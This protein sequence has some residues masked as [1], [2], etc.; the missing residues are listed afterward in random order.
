[1]SSEYDVVVVGGVAAGLTMSGIAASLGAKTV[2]IE[3][4]RLGGDCTW[5][6]CVPSK[7]LLK[8]AGIAQTVRTAGRYGI[9]CSAPA[10]DFD[11]IREQLRRL[12]QSIYDDADSPAR[13][14]ALGV[15]VLGAAAKFRDPRTI[16]AAGHGLVRGRIMV[17]ATGA[18]PALPSI[19]GLDTADYLTSES[20]FELA[21]L[22]KRLTVIGAGP[23]GVELAQA[24]NRLGSRVTVLE[25][26]DRIL[27][28]H[29]AELAARLRAF[30]AAEGV[31]LVTGVQA[32]AVERKGAEQ[33]A[34]YVAADG[35]RRRAAFDQLLIATGRIARTSGI[36]LE[37]AGVR[38][39]PR[40]VRVN[41]RCRTSVRHIYAIGDVTGRY[42][43]THMSEHMARV[44]ATNAVLRLRR[45]LDER[46]VPGVV[47]TD[48]ELARVGA[49]EAD[50]ARR[51]IRY[52]TYA[53]P[54]SKLDRAIID[55]AEGGL[56]KLFARPASGR[57]L[58][59]A[60]LGE[61][62]GEL[63][64]E[65]AVAMRA[66]L[67]LGR[68]SNTIHPYPTFEQG[69]RRAADQWYARRASP[70]AVRLLQRLFR[71][72]GRIACREPTDIV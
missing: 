23:V 5:T 2:L 4:D 13:M 65:V 61:S 11:C 72:R 55:G 63:I 67:A 50:L 34:L 43:H 66:G 38:V 8:A 19:P 60:I 12:R 29:D 37:R 40:G 1:M 18:E 57:V 59:A 9:R 39:T 20:V 70:R 68:L 32:V 26:Q 15:D 58:G 3:R 47:F 33:Q 35:R 64:S 62:A 21:S 71:Y 52:A 14:A 28:A 42:A 31:H 24:F 46:T 51:G 22:P 41:R 54:Y 36:G 44:A 6:G 48:P 45:S 56:I 49:G 69:V 10:V 25:A 27:A 16:E 7:A 17:I 30:L 53:F